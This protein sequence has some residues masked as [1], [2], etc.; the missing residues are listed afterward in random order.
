MERSFQ[1]VDT[2][3]AIGSGTRARVLRAASTLFSTRGFAGTSISAIRNVSGAMPSSIYWEFGS[4]EGLLAA[5]LKDAAERWLEQARASI[6]RASDHLDGSGLERL[7]AALDQL[8]DATASRPEFHR[9]LLLLALE[10]RDASEE[11]LEIVRNVR[12]LAL[13]GLAQLYLETGVVRPDTPLAAIEDLTRA[14]LAFF[15]GALVAAQID[16]TKANLR[17]MFA[18]LRAGVVAA[19]PPSRGD[20]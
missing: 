10:R 20:A 1:E 8:A 17:R 14:S 7:E 16:P 12:E 5:V 4:K 6:Q 2:P 3:A 15:D 11:T 9:L 13:R 19:M 18:L